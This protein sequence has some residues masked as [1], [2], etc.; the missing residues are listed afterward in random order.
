MKEIWLIA[1][2]SMFVMVFSSLLYPNLAHG[3]KRSI[4]FNS[5]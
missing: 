2:F 3:E 1:C 4:N 5:G